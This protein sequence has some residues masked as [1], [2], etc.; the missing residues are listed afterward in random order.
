MNIKLFILTL[1]S[2][3]GSGIFAQD[4]LT[5]KSKN[6]PEN[7]TVWVF[8]PQ[9]YQSGQT[10]PLIFLL[11]G[12][13]GNY[14]QWD[15]IMDAQKYADE[16]GIIIVCPDGL[17]NSW[18]LNSPVKSNWQYESFFFDELYPDILKKYTPD[19]QKI[20][21]TGLSMGGHGAMYL[22]IQKPELFAGAG[23]TSGGI[24]L[25]D[26]YGKWELAGLLGN[27]AKDDEI[28]QKYSVIDNIE[29][30]KGNQKP[31]IFDCGASD[32]FYASNNE[33]KQKCDSLKLN[34]TYIS[35]P[36]AHNRV[37]WAKSIRQ[38]FTFFKSKINQE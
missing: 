2:F 29:R 38:Q 30:L 33:L 19:K 10:L 34:A 31:I 23:S 18:Y 21:I 12:Y 6:L 26:G 9:Q 22:F 25:S 35:Q 11:H 8:K 36:G 37:Y 32:F 28:W 3:W 15:S 5:Y 14:K 24:K 16:F 7:D 13:S 1:L 17:F 27:P 4:Q 20:F